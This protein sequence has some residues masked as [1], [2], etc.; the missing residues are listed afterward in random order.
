MKYLIFS[1]CLLSLNAYGGSFSGGSRSS[2]S[3]LRSISSPS[4]FTRTIPINSSP[5]INNIPKSTVPSNTKINTTENTQINNNYYSTRTTPVYLTPQYS[6]NFFEQMFF[7]DLFFSPHINYNQNN[8]DSY[9][10]FFNDCKSS[11]DK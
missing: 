8:C 9:L 2:F 6:S 1:L 10:D 4:S 3:S 11:E 7:F 5:K